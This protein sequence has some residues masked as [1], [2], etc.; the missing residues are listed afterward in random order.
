MGFFMVFMLTPWFWQIE[1][2]P[3]AE[4]PLR[5]LGGGL[6]IVAAPASIIIWFGMVASCILEHR[7][8][9]GLKVLWFVLF[10]TTAMFGAAIYFFRVYSKQAQGTTTVPASP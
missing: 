1:A 2:M 4:L 10:F 8:S 7:S 6:G 5:V 9:R 3:R